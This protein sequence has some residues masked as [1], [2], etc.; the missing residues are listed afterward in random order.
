MKLVSANAIQLF[1]RRW[2]HFIYV[3]A[4]CI[5]VPLFVVPLSLRTTTMEYGSFAS[6]FEVMDYAGDNFEFGHRDPSKLSLF[7]TERSLEPGFSNS[8]VRVTRFL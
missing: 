2:V 5:Y 1:F 6:G 7:S 4:C 3:I 8:S